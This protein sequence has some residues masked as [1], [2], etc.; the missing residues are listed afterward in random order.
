MVKSDSELSPGY[1]AQHFDLS[2]SILPIDSFH[3]GGWN[4]SAGGSRTKYE[5]TSTGE[6]SY[7][8]SR[9]F[10]AALDLGYSTDWLFSISADTSKATE[11]QFTQTTKG[12]NLTYSYT[13]GDGGSFSVGAG[14]YEGQIKQQISFVILNRTVEREVSL[15]QKESE[16]SLSWSPA[17]TL[18]ISLRASGYTYSKSK[19]DLQTAFQNR[20]LNTFTTDLISSISGLPESQVKLGINYQ[21]NEDWDLAANTSQTKRIVDETLSRRSELLATTYVNAWMI[22]GGFSRLQSEGMADTSALLQLGYSWD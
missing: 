4:L 6:I 2:H 12:A 8:N 1:T 22:G 7:A 18:S 3:F 15:D 10:S 21:L 14:Y 17:K 16:I 11:T 19:Q 5:D 20:F 9:D 13:Y